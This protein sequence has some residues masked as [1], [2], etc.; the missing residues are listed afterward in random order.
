MPFSPPWW[1]LS[2]LLLRTAFPYFQSPICSPHF[3]DLVFLCLRLLHRIL[4]SCGTTFLSEG[5]TCAPPFFDPLRALLVWVLATPPICSSPPP[6]WTLPPSI[7]ELPPPFPLASSLLGC[8]ETDLPSVSHNILEC[9]SSLVS[10]ES[11]ERLTRVVL[12]YFWCFGHAPIA[13]V[14]SFMC[15]ALSGCRCTA[16]SFLVCVSL[17]VG[18]FVCAFFLLCLLAFVWSQ[19]IPFF[20]SVDCLISFALCMLIIVALRVVCVSF[21]CVVL[22]LGGVRWL[23]FVRCCLCLVYISIVLLLYFFLLSF[24]LCC[25]FFLCLFFSSYSALLFC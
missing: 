5:T 21:I 15:F 17:A 1:Y 22:C 19:W 25:A 13:F 6:I 3:S 24:L 9:L 18:W 14:F 12:S 2:Y 4:T 20:Y 23:S 10:C 8:S 11:L 16:C 7:W